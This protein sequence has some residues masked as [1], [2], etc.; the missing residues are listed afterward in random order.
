LKSLDGKDLKLYPETTENLVEVT[1]QKSILC[2]L[3]DSKKVSDTQ[4]NHN[5]GQ[6]VVIIIELLFCIMPA[7]I[8][9]RFGGILGYLLVQHPES[10]YS[11]PVILADALK[12]IMEYYFGIG[13]SIWGR[14]D[15]EVKIIVSDLIYSP[16]FLT[17]FFYDPIFPVIKSLAK[18]ISIVY[19][20]F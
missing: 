17:L 3:I 6:S 14:H 2:K 18:K 12:T 7:I 4:S 1:R 13:I 19:G 9:T 15:K 20:R 8:A 10:I 11:P 16:Y 5:L